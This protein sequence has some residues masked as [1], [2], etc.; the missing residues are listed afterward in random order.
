VGAEV[1]PP[2]F[3]AVGD[4]SGGVAGRFAESALDIEQAGVGDASLNG[5]VE[6]VEGSRFDLDGGLGFEGAFR[7][8]GQAD[9]V[10]LACGNAIGVEVGAE[11]AGSFW[12]YLGYRCG[13]VAIVG[14]LG[15]VPGIAQ[16]AIESEQERQQGP[17]LECIVAVGE[18]RGHRAEQQPQTEQANDPN[19]TA[20]KHGCGLIKV[21]R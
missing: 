17:I 5:A 14:M 15:V 7:T 11:F 10:D 19:G 21:F 2:G 18:G 8:D 3:G 12:G 4:G 6:I 1:A 20:F 13:V 16:P 9:V